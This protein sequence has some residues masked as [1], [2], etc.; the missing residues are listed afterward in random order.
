M[1]GDRQAFNAHRRAAV[2]EGRC[3][4]YEGV[5]W[6]VYELAAPYDRR[7]IPSLVFEADDMVRR[8]RNYPADWRRLS[9]ETLMAL[10]W[11]R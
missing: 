4:V 8:I 2:A 6:Q 7:S 9:D 10:S 11:N 1:A 5:I 3:V